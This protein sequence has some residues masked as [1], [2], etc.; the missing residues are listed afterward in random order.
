MLGK[1]QCTNMN[2]E[3]TRDISR[4][5]S[6]E[7]YLKSLNLKIRINWG[8]AVNVSRAA[9]LSQKTNQFNFWTTRRYTDGDVRR[10]LED[11][12]HLVAT[13]AVSDRYGDYGVVGLL[14][15]QRGLKSAE[16]FIDTL[17]LSCRVLGRN[18]EY[19]FLNRIIGKLK[20]LGVVNL[21][22]EFI[23]TH[24]NTQVAQF[25][26]ALNFNL[27]SDGQ[28]RKYKLAVADYQL[29]QYRLYR[30]EKW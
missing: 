29:N 25:Y 2:R 3:R 23:P 5:E 17:L 13:F 20:T 10:M 8:S 30:G 26:D 18:V 14:I 1:P 6:V 22:A 11:G 24:K 21:Y 15:I 16:A 4:F 28:S 12:E 27:L 9:Q 7:D 19:V